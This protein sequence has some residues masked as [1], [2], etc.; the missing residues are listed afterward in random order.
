M[1]NSLSC[2]A[3]SSEEHGVGA[4]GGTHGQ[5]IESKNFS[6]SLKN[7]SLGSL[8]DVQS[9]NSQVGGNLDE[10]LVVS[11]AIFPAAVLFIMAAETALRET[12]GRLVWDMKRRFRMTLLKGA[13]VR[14]ARK[15]YSLMIMLR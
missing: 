9:N 4:S 7:S 12:G 11:Q 6:S 3:L 8:S 14:R 1:S 13:S 15:R 10:T 5:L 2:V